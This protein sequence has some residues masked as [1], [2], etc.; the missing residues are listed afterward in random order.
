MPTHAL[1]TIGAAATELSDA[2]ADPTDATGRASLLEVLAGITDPRARRGVRH[3]CGAVLAGACA[4]MLAGC[5]SFVAIAEWIASIPAEVAAALGIDPLRRPSEPT[6]R[7][8]IERLDGPSFDTAIHAFIAARSTASVDESPALTGWAVDGKTSRG[9]RTTDTVA[10]HFLA[11]MNITTR[12][13]IGQ[14]E[15]GE[16]TNETTRLIP[17]LGAIGA[18]G[19]LVTADALH[20]VA[21]LARAIVTDCRAHYLL[22]VKGNQP[23]LKRQ[24]SQLPWK[25]IPTAHREDDTGHGR[26]ERRILKVCEVD[27]LGFPHAKQAL[28]IERKRRPR[29]TK[30]WSTETVYAI[31][32]LDALAAQPATLAHFARQHWQIE[33]AIHYVRDVT[34]GEDA[35][36]IRT[37]SGPHVMTCLRNLTIALHRLDGA[38]NI[39]SALRHTAWNAHTVL[40]KVLTR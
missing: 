10:P 8:L 13:V 24:L 15:V 4:A 7:R 25:D 31:T 22:T 19:V 37:G 38:T 21:S 28:R 33:N 32:D 11:A 1:S 40:N 27:G 2:G 14:L 5:V 3:R 29:G 30:K 16:K 6:I 20:A 34:L 17:L 26:H 36:R 9:A 12:T 39:A 23:K 35:S 18:H